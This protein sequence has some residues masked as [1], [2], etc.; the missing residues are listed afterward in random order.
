MYIL[1]VQVGCLFGHFGVVYG[2]AADSRAAAG[3]SRPA[4]EGGGTVL[5]GSVP[6]Q[7][8]HTINLRRSLEIA[9]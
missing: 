2:Q 3:P 6:C 8:H 7:C 1:E 9:I 5:T 4:G